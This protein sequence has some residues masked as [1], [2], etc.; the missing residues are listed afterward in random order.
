MKSS[1]VRGSSQGYGIPYDE[2][3]GGESERVIV[4]LIH[5]LAVN[6]QLQALDLDLSARLMAE[7]AYGFGRALSAKAHSYIE[8]DCEVERYP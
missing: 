6:S 3:P 1:P 8:R 5:R 7:V 4:G 2:N